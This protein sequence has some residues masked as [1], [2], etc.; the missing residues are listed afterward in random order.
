MSGYVAVAAV[1]ASG[2]LLFLA[3]M[4]VRRLL[5]PRAPLAAS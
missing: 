2:V 1:L 5:A 3:A 4:T